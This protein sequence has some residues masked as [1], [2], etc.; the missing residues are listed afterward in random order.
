MKSVS[1]AITKSNMAAQ[2]PGDSGPKAKKRGK[3]HAVGRG[4]VWKG[5]G[6]LW[7]GDEMFDS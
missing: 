4:D 2:L 6:M 5:R 3:L 1:V 7:E